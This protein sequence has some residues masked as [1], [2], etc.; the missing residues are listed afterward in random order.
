MPCERSLC[1][2]P[3]SVTGSML[4]LIQRYQPFPLPLGQYSLGVKKGL[5]LEPS[6]R[7]SN[8]RFVAEP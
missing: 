3:F 2:V 6:N 8:P 5:G 4:P 7:H 1:V